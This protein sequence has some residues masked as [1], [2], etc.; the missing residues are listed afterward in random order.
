LKWIVLT[1]FLTS[2]SFLTSIEIGVSVFFAA[3]LTLVLRKDFRR[4]FLSYLLSTVIPF[5]LF[6]GYLFS[7][8]ALSDYWQTQWIVITKMTHTFIQSEPVPENLGEVVN[9]LF[10]V[11]DKYFRQMTAVYCYAFFFVLWIVRLRQKKL[12]VLDW[13]AL[14]VALYGLAIYVT[15][16]RNLWS[17]VFEMSLQ[18]EK[19][20][21]FYLLVQVFLWMKEQK[22]NWNIVYRIGLV[23]V[24]LSSFI[25]SI[26]RLNKRF[27]SV[28]WAVYKITGKD[29]M[30]LK[31]LNKESSQSV[32]FSR[33]QNMVVPSW[34]AA[35][36][37]QLKSFVDKN[38]APDEKIWMYPEL[39]TMHFLLDR[40][41]IEKQPI[42][43]LAWMDEDYFNRYD[44][45]LKA[46]P[47]R[48]AIWNKKMPEYYEKIHLSVAANR[49]KF[50]KHLNFLNENYS[51]F[52]TTPTYNVYVYKPNNWQP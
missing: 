50:E 41:W 25:F 47:P 14:S 20:I 36:L 23:G 51:I 4:G 15:G 7:Q 18:P 40:P 3:V 37:D 6:L 35:D 10:V 42:P 8:G 28:R 34:Q 48:F 52:T 1:G 9:S 22:G 39:D 31:P 21:L 32:N 43:I 38:V 33:I 11:T 30:T 5:L 24:I 46:H 17:S 19:I 2:I 12:S 13:S 45:E 27:F 26:A 49:K 16:F 44:Q 29:T